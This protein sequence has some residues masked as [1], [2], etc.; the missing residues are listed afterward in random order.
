MH[1]L[2]DCITF[3]DENYIF[4]LRYNTIKDYVDYFVVCESLYDHKGNKKQLNFDL[5]YQ[6]KDNKIIYI[7]LEK[8]FPI[9]TNGWEKQAIQREFILENL[10]SFHEEDFIFFSDPDEIPNPNIL[11]DFNLKK[12]YG[13]FLQKTFNYKFNL[14]N[15]FE[16]P[17]EGTRVCMK[18]NLKSIDFMRQKILKK[19]LSYSF[20]RFT[21]EKNIELFENAGW[22]FNNIMKPEKI[23]KKLKTFAH[24]E[25]S[26]D[27]YSSIDVI[28][29]KIDNKQDLFERDYKFEKIKIDHSFPDYLL[30]NYDYYK[31]YIL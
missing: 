27:K 10:N 7:V 6:K 26:S 23:S 11:K 28:K 8:S 21:K 17:W 29:K 18:K 22:H 5:K 20:L 19:N 30:K 24:N 12:K 15:P 13:I 31:E 3:Y 9:N 1:K 25:Y 2:I 4:D 14:Y 16:S